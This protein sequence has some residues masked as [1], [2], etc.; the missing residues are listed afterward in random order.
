MEASILTSIKAVLGLA[1]DYTAFD[2]DIIMHINTAFDDLQDLGYGPVNGFYITDASAEWD[3]Y[4]TTDVPF[5]HSIKDLVFL[6]VQ[7]LFDSNTATSYVIAA[8]ERQILELQWRINTRR[9][10]LLYPAT[11]S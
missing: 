11:E 9:E 3:S 6:K 5:N 8:R 1:E 7:L 4:L 10:A 2:E